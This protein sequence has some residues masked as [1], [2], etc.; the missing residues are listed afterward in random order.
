MAVAVLFVHLRI[1]F[2]WTEGGFEY[3]L[4]WGVVA[5]FFVVCGGGRYSADALIGREI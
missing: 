3:P 2:F 4:F 1:G 5:L